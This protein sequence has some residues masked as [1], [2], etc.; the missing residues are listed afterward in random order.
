[1]TLMMSLEVGVKA[2]ALGTIVTHV[3]ADLEETHHSPL[4]GTPNVGGFRVARTW[5][6]TQWTQRFVCRG[7]THEI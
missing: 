6:T 1:M 7:C 4:P 3:K 5:G 2:K